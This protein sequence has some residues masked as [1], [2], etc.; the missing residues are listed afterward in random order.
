MVSSSFANPLA[1]KSAWCNQQDWTRS[2]VDVNAYAGSTVQFRY[3]LGSDSSVSKDGWYLDDVSVQGCTA[4]ANPPIANATPS[5]F[6]FAVSTGGNTSGLLNIADT[7]GDSLVWS[8]NEA[9]ATCASPADVPWLSVSAASGLVN[10][11]SAQDVTIG[12]DA[13]SLAAG[14]YSAHAALELYAEI[15]EEAGALAR[16]EG[17]AS[18]FGADF[19]GLPRNTEQITLTRTPWEVPASFA[20]GQD[21]LIPLCAGERIR[22]RL[23]NPT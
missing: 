14:V 22:W 3:R 19:Y 10:G 9:A 2:V 4:S 8:A 18:E 7:G 1:G 12:V 15:F 17:F 16:L 21:E 20:F 23:Q 13:A 6:D 5:Q 11:G